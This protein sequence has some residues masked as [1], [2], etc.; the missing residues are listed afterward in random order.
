MN[1]NLS[2]RRSFLKAASAA[3]TAFTIVPRHVLGQGQTPPSQKLHVAAIGVGGMGRGDVAS[4]AQAGENIVALCDPDRSHLDAL[5]KKYPGAR[6][7]ADFR[8]MLETQ[9][10]IDAVVIATPDH[11]HAVATAMAMSLGKHVHCQKPLTHSVHEARMIGQLARETKVATQMGNFGQAGEEP[12]RV[13]EMIWAGAIGTLKEVHA[14][15][16]RNPDISP[17]GIARPKDTPPCP[18]HL[19]WDLWVGPAPMRP[20][21]P[22]YH[23]FAW[24]GWWDFGTGVL[25]DIGCHEFSAVF[26]TMKIGHPVSVEACSTNWQRPREISTETAPLASITHYKFA[27]SDTHGPLSI[28]WY[29]GGMRPP[30]PEALDPDADFAV[31]DG[32][33]YVGDK[34]IMLRSRLIPESKRREFGRPPEKLARSPGHWKE[35]FDACRGGKPAGS[36]FADHAA[37]LTEV[38]LL[39]N[40]AIRMNQKLEWDPVNMKFPN[41]PEADRWVKEPYRPGYAL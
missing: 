23:P 28:F 5:A 29:D 24:R 7:Y 34:G 30:R 20:Y 17:R 37:H 8:K 11:A 10:D 18:A 14:W 15:S 9:K 21:H 12:R 31:N 32:T 40:I 2:S 19:D 4:C 36:N 35:F 22:C 41:C 6:L 3:A 1:K 13:A 25:G 39:G 38:V 16:N 27:A 26:K 33:M